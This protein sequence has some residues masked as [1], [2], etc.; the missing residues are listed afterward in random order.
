MVFFY[1]LVGRVERRPNPT[2]LLGCAVAPPNLRKFLVGRV[3]RRP[4]PTILLG[5][6]VAPPNLRMVFFYFG[7]GI[8][9]KNRVSGAAPQKPGV[10]SLTH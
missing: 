5:C 1:F 6:A 3:E 8:D 4:N 2:I 7:E 10:K 9:L